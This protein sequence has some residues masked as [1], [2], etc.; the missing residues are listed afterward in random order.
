[1]FGQ[2]LFGSSFGNGRKMYMAMIARLV[3][4]FSASFST[5]NTSV[6][7]SLPSIMPYCLGV[8]N[9]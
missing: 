9:F 2:G 4:G 8:F 7:T 1:V 3:F 6:P 5:F